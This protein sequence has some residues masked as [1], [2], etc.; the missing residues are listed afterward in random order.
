M[1]CHVKTS[2]SLNSF[3][4]IIQCWDGETFVLAESANIYNFKTI[5][6]HENIILKGAT[7]L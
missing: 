5:E 4:A 7:K 6:S 1:E 2:D 3:K